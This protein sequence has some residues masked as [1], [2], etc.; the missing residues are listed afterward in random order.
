MGHSECYSN[1][2]LLAIFLFT[3]WLRGDTLYL[4]VDKRLS[5][6]PGD[7]YAFLNKR[8]DTAVFLRWEIPALILV[9]FLTNAGYLATSITYLFDLVNIILL[10]FNAKRVSGFF[11]QHNGYSLL[12]IC[13]CLLAIASGLGG[14]VSPLCI[15]WELISQ[16]RIPLYILLVSA[17][18]TIDDLESVLRFLFRIQPLNAAFALVE[19]FVF[20]LTGDCCGGL[21]GIDAGSN[22]LLNMYL[23]FVSSIACCG[24][25]SGV[26]S[27]QGALSFASTLVGSFFVATLAE[28]KFFYFEAAVIIIIAV[29]LGKKS[30][31]MATAIALFVAACLVGLSALA[32]YFPDSYDMLFDSNQMLSYDDGSNVATSGYGISRFGAISQIDE[33]FFH[34]DTLDQVV[35]FGFGSATMSSIDQFCSPFYWTYGWLRYY[36]SQIAMLYLQNGYVG[37]AIYFALMLMPCLFAVLKRKELESLGGRFW[38]TFTVAVTVLFVMNCFYNASSRS[39][40]ALLWAVCLAAPF[41]VSQKGEDNAIR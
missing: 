17:F 9:Q 20:N 28:I 2:Y 18:W 19:Y 34:G 14:G 31:K 5:R 12:L 38:L 27:S 39:Y 23:V 3:F 32:V 7:R 21:F 24:Y 37:L 40:A 11:R 15:T 10:I 6:N 22:M 35:G 36:Y 26:K 4:E 8:F 13:Y 1:L 41:L 30:A 33:L 25:L 29:L 16:L